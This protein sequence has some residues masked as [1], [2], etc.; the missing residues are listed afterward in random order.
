[1]TNATAPTKLKSGA[2]LAERVQSYEVGYRKP[3]T[4]TRFQKGHSGNPRGR[5]KG[6]KSTRALLELAL[7][8]PVTII[9]G[10]EQKVVEQRAVL[11][12]SLVAR[13]IKGDPRSIAMVLKLMQEHGVNASE[14]QPITRIIR[15]IV[16]PREIRERQQKSMNGGFDDGQV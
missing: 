8:S 15:E 1:M 2:S 7:A 10:G 12:K 6:S 3:P 5:P 11:F 9:E 13:A 14:H 16:E 4:A